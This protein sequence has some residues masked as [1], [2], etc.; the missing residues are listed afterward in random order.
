[1]YLVS[2][3]SRYTEE[4]SLT[5]SQTAALCSCGAKTGWDGNFKVHLE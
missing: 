2:A 5:P 3:E 4:S 1:M